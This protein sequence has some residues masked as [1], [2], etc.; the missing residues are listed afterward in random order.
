MNV[1]IILGHP[2][3]DSLCGVLANAYAEDAVAAG[4]EVRRLHLV[5]L[6]F[7][8]HVYTIPPKPQA[9]EYVSAIQY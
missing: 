8:P 6:D 7:D 9:F 3:S 4:I 2:C 1:R 5:T